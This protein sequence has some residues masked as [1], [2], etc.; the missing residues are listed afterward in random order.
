MTWHKRIFVIKVVG[1]DLFKCKIYEIV[2]HNYACPAY[3]TVQRLQYCR[4]YP[5]KYIPNLAF[6][7][8]KIFT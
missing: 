4:A 3:N 8:T 2:T 7:L 1:V 5:I 6:S